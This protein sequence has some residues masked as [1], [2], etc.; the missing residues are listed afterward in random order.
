MARTEEREPEPQNA[1]IRFEEVHQR[2]RRMLGEVLH[3][4]FQALTVQLGAE[5]RQDFDER[6]QLLQ[7][8]SIA[9]SRR[10][11]VLQC[12]L[13]RIL[14]LAR[15]L[16]VLQGLRTMVSSTAGSPN[17][18]GWASVFLMPMT[19]TIGVY[20]TQLVADIGPRGRPPG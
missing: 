6:F 19:H 11:S 1:P 8:G 18:L 3:Q 9:M 14:R 10:S 17:S 16:R 7:T 2:L 13:L 5:W 4:E 12:R 15:I 20:L